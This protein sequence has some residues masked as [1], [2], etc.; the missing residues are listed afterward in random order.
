MTTKQDLIEDIGDAIRLLEPDDTLAYI[1]PGQ[2]SQHVGMA[3]DVAA[4]SSSARRIFDDADQILRFDLTALCFEGPEDE[5]RL[6]SNAQP[7][8]LT[9]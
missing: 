1:F 8:I 9:A 5:L 7:A 2:G 4:S 3:K 6:T